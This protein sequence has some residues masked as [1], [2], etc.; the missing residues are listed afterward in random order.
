MA[1]K[2][3]ATAEEL[4]AELDRVRCESLRAEAERA[5]AE[6]YKTRLEKRDREIDQVREQLQETLLAAEGQLVAAAARIAQVSQPPPPSSLARDLDEARV[7]T[8]RVQAEL[9]EL[10]AGHDDLKRQF[11]SVRVESEGLRGSAAA[12]QAAVA[13]HDTRAEAAAAAARDALERAVA[14]KEEASAARAELLRQGKPEEEARALALGGQ[15][16]FGDIKAQLA[17]TAQVREKQLGEDFRDATDQIGALTHLQAAA[18]ERESKLQ[19]ALSAARE[20]EAAL[21]AELR[22]VRGKHS[23]ARAQRDDQLDAARTELRK[24]RADLEEQL[25][26]QGRA[27]AHAGEL[28]AVVDSLG[29]ERAA[30]RSEAG[31]MRARVEML[32]S[33]EERARRL[34]QELEEQRG[35]IEFLKQELA[36]ANSPRAGVPPPLPKTEGA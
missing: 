9:A 16:R 35:E 7:Q 13:V 18:R 17:A 33:A 10:R 26:S 5:R 27:E 34:A 11:D 32:S 20:R 36:R 29:R 6:E 24:L 28:Q 30:L 4:R 3:P 15:E 19:Q 1:A 8:A 21:E 12:L 23:E 25:E 14:A 31:A 22:T 2:T